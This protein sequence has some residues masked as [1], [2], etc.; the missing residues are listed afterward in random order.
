MAVNGQHIATTN[1]EES[2]DLVKAAPFTKIRR[3]VMLSQARRARLRYLLADFFA[4]YV[5]WIAFVVVRRR[6]IEQLPGIVLD[7]Q[8]FINAAI[9]CRLLADRLWDCRT[10]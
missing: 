3:R 10:V 5:V 8:Q 2:P 7:G 1:S 4:S 6:V 9:I